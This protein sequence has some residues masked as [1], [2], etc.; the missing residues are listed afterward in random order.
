[1]TMVWTFSRFESSAAQVRLLVKTSRRLSSIS[2]ASLVVVD[3]E[4]KNMVLFGRTSSLALP[5]MMFFSSTFRAERLSSRLSVPT[6]YSTERAPPCVRTMRRA[7][8]SGLRSVRIVISDTSGKVFLSW[9]KVTVPRSVTNLAMA[10]R[11]SVILLDMVSPDF[12]CRTIR[13]Q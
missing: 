11:R 9:A 5:A 1:M 8:S 2:L 10:S 13:H 7:S 6:T 3:P 12:A 4:S